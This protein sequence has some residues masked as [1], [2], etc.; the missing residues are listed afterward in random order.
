MR[1]GTVK[2]AVATNAQTSINVPGKAG[3]SIYL[4]HLSASY[5]ANVSGFRTITIK[6]EGTIIW[7]YNT[8]KDDFKNF[9]FDGTPLKITAGNDLDVEF[10]ASG[11]A[12]TN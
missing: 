5:D 6:D 11:N 9:G 7:Q 3:R 4:F 12:G 1:K 8:D 2:T 10:Q